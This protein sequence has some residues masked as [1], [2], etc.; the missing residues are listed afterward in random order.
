MCA[1]GPMATEVGDTLAPLDTSGSGVYGADTAS[2]LYDYDAASVVHSPSSTSIR[3]DNAS[4]STYTTKPMR[5]RPFYPVTPFHITDEEILR[6]CIK[7]FE[8]DGRKSDLKGEVVISQAGRRK[9]AL[10]LPQA[11][12]KNLY[13]VQSALND[14]R[15][16]CIGF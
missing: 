3:G 13:V 1:V 9:V 10:R 5:E 4:K 16:N 15:T 11:W 6:V 8:Y 7:G 14:S 12:K 2:E